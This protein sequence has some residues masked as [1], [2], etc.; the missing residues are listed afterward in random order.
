LT[1][2]DAA[3]SAPHALRL[4]TC[5]CRLPPS[6]PTP[7]LPL[8]MTLTD[9]LDL[10]CEAAMDTEGGGGNPNRATA[11]PVVIVSDPTAAGV[12]IIHSWVRRTH[13]FVSTN[14]YNL[15]WPP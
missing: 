3:V 14:Q 15:R 12:K 2:A 10:T 8:M 9:D 4:I 7:H 5:S 13:P 1:A 11:V 6:P